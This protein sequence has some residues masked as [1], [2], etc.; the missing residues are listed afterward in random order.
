MIEST[1]YI[2]KE[3][4][5]F[6]NKFKNVRVRYEYDELALVHIIEV[7]PNEVYH[8]DKNY[9]EWELQMFDNFIKKFPCENINFI[10]D[11]ALVGIKTPVFSKSGIE[12][13]ENFKDRYQKIVASKQFKTTYENKN[14][15]DSIFID[16]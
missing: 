11:D 9:I 14:I 3:L 7:L 5:L 10:S 6:I 13:K 1:K 8:L 16:D 15:G 2:I 12:Y 4:K